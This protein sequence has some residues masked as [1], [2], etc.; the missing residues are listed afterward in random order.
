MSDR[1]DPAA[2]AKVALLARLKLSADEAQRASV[3][4]TAIL[5]Y[6][7]RLR[8]VDLTGVEPLAT[9]LEL[10]APLDRDQLGPV[11]PR[12]T[13]MAMAPDHDDPFLKVPKVL[14]DGGGA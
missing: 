10:A 14:G 7:E 4:L 5:G 6:V 3:D 8:Q 13:F 9:P 11:L 2:V 1:L 12:S